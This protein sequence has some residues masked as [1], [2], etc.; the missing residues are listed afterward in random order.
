MAKVTTVKISPGMN[1]SEALSVAKVLGATVEQLRRTGE[2]QIHHALLQER[3]RINSR[4][5]DTPRQFVG[6]LRKLAELQGVSTL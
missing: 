2:L 5:K 4:R 1:Q 6:W 3:C